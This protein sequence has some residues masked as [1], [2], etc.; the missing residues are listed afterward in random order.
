MQ[1]K[2]DAIEE[3]NHRRK[4]DKQ[5]IKRK[6]KLKNTYRISKKQ[7][8]K[9]KKEKERKKEKIYT[10]GCLDVWPDCPRAKR[11]IVAGKVVARTAQRFPINIRW[12]GQNPARVIEYNIKKALARLVNQAVAERRLRFC[13]NFG[14]C[15]LMTKEDGG[16]FQKNS[17]LSGGRVKK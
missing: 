17:A 4:K 12:A 10:L 8:R 11:A 15:Q 3:A 16:F 9:R 5:Q 1:L 13:S 2:E 6:M 7:K 14:T